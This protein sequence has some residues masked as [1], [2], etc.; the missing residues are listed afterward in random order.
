VPLQLIS[1]PDAVWM[2]LTA[3]DIIKYD[4]PTDNFSKSDTLRGQQLLR[5]PRYQ[6]PYLQEEIKKFL[7]L[8][9]KSEQQSLASKSLSFVVD[10]Y[11]PDKFKEIAKMQ[12]SGKI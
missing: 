12:K 6:K 1:T 9:K 8:K 4:L 5:D 2:G 11:L 10:E 7:Q 3:S